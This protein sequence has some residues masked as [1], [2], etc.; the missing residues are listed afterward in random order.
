MRPYERFWGGSYKGRTVTFGQVVHNALRKGSGDKT[1]IIFER[2]WTYGI[3]FG[4]C[5]STS[6]NLVTGT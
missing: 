2:A 4:K 6:E 3:W 5:I 1:D